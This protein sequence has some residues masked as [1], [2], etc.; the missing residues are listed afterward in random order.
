[1]VSRSR[2]RFFAPA[3]ATLLVAVVAHAKLART[4][5][6]QVSFHATG[7]GGLS[8]IGTTNE[9]AVSETDT[10]V[11]VTVPLAKLDTKID[12]RN[13]HMRDKYLEV[14]K[15]PNAELH[16]AKAAVQAPSGKANGTLT[17]HGQTK[18]VTFTYATKPEGAATAVTGTVRVVMTDYGIEKPG[19]AG[20]S[21]KPDVDV[22][23]VFR[24]TKD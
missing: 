18:P 13:R 7:P 8:I 17:L 1:M 11:V 23:V 19:Y 14:A 21:V 20:V 9:L 5:D 6:A 2:L 22:D 10:D 16:V 24:V 3:L 15:Y 4:G 12:L